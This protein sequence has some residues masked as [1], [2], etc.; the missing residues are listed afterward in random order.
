MRVINATAVADAVASL[1]VKAGRVL[2]AEIHRALFAAQAGETPRGRESLRQLLDNAALSASLGLPLCQ[3]CGM[4][5]FFVSKGQDLRIEG[6]PLREAINQGMV[7]GYKDGF[8]R[9][10]TCDP[11]TRVNRGDNSPAVIHF[12]IVEGDGLHIVMVPEGASADNASRVEMLPPDATPDTVRRFVLNTVAGACQ[13]VCAPVLVGIGIGGNLETAALN[14]K[15]SLLR[16]LDHENPDP[17]LAGLEKGLLSDLNKLGTGPLGLGG[18]TTCLAV[19]AQSAPC[20]PDALPLAVYIQ[21]HC[22][23]RSEVSL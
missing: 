2:P 19:K 4:A 7:K 6:M 21:C 22:A 11:F 12:D 3:D 18:R 20:H 17:L 13:N 9:K 1:C 14:A 5:V 10:S 23:R 16:P 8:L 15:K